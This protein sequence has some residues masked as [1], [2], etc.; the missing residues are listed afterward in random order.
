MWLWLNECPLLPPVCTGRCWGNSW[1]LFQAVRGLGNI[2]SFTPYLL[3]VWS[4]WDHPE[5]MDL[6][7]M[8]ISIQKD[9]GGIW[10]WQHLEGPPRRPDH[11]LSRL[12]LGL[13]HLQQNESDINEGDIQQRRD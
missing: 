5:D 13:E 10:M 6:R 3:L 7:E 11:V 9:L 2:E 12:D 4:E 8:C 1:D